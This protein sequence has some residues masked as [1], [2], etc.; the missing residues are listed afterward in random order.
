VRLVAKQACLQRCSWDTVRLIDLAL[1]F[2]NTKIKIADS[3]L[4]SVV[5][6]LLRVKVWGSRFGGVAE[7]YMVQLNLP[8]AA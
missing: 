6:G 2:V 3:R 1:T 4:C 8:G 7:N 5:V